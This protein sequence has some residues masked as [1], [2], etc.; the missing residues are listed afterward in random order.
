MIFAM[1]LMRISFLTS[2]SSQTINLSLYLDNQ[3]PVV[4]PIGSDNAGYLS[5]L[6]TGISSKYGSKVSVRAD[7]TDT[8]AAT[9]DYNYLLPIQKQQ[10]TLLGGI[11]F[12][13]ALNTDPIFKF[14]TLVSTRTPTSV[15][16]LQTLA[17][18]T[19][20]INVLGKPASTSITVISYPLPRTYQQSQ[21]NNTIS[22]FFGS[23]IF[24]LALAFKFASIMSFI[25]K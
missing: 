16:Y 6:S 20:L 15:F 9:F 2:F 23:F 10:S 4:I 7:S 21:I 12:E 18:E 1:L 14:N 3:N 24:T 13:N 22:G 8:T 5:T 25:V 11:F 19:I 17:A